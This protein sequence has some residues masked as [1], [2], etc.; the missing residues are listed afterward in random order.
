VNSKI[1]KS[2]MVRFLLLGS[3]LA[4]SVLAQD[5]VLTV[6]ANPLT[7]A[8]LATPYTITGCSQRS[9]SASFI[10]C[11]IYDNAGTIELYAPLVVDAGDKVNVDFVKPV[12]PTIPQGATVACWFGSNGDSVTLTGP[13]ATQCVNGLGSSAFGQFA[14]CNGDKFM[15]VSANNFIQWDIYIYLTTE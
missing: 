8:G 11:A 10:E 15:T 3:L 9:D 6:P 12:V 2:K 4:G 14:H 7:A 13:G 5:C 1:I